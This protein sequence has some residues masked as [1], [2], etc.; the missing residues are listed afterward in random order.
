MTKYV[1]FL[2]EASI[3][4]LNILTVVPRDN[5]LLGITGTDQTFSD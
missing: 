1:F 4:H 2:T 3:S 5:L